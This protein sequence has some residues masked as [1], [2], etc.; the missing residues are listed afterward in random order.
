MSK[1]KSW[2]Q[3]NVYAKQKSMWHF[4]LGGEG[5]RDRYSLANNAYRDFDK[6][7]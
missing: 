3:L 5:K 7:V 6:N 4:F 1:D 2:F